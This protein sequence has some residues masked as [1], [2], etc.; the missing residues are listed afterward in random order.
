MYLYL[1]TVYTGLG[2]SLD[3]GNVTGDPG[4]MSGKIVIPTPDY[5]TIDPGL[6]SQRLIQGSK[7]PET[8]ALVGTST[9]AQKYGVWIALGLGA[10]VIGGSLLAKPKRIK[11]TLKSP[12]I[13]AEEYPI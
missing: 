10:V 3:V 4:Y 13:V 11:K 9:F 5:K 1:E 7:I 12:Q 6:V 8:P 2:Y